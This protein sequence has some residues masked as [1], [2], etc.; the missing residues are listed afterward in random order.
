M[1]LPLW[2]VGDTLALLFL[3]SGIPR[4]GQAGPAPE[5]EAGGGG[6]GPVG[7]GA[8]GLGRRALLPGSGADWVVGEGCP[9]PAHGGREW[10][11]RKRRAG[12]GLPC[13]AW[14][15]AQSSSVCRG[16]GGGSGLPGTRRAAS[17]W[18]RGWAWGPCQPERLQACRMRAVGHSRRFASGRQCY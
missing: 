10:A 13:W 16:G 1:T 8:G 17:P 5:R 6:N 14:A 15:P 12:Q 4:A 7:G 11:D 9:G 18:E 3:G 2:L